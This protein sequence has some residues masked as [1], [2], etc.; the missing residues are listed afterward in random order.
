MYA[1]PVACV[2]VRVRV[3]VRVKVRMVRVYNV[4]LAGHS[5]PS[6][7]PLTI[8]KLGLSDCTAFSPFSVAVRV[9]EFM[10]RA[11][12]AVQVVGRWTNGW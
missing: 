8:D 12:T 4:C 11:S 3:R 5:H 1:L 10:A 6:P 7:P 9:T 2:R